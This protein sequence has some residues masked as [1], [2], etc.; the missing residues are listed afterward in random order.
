MPLAAAFVAMVAHRVQGGA[1][2]EHPGDTLTTPP[3][4]SRLCHVRHRAPR[5]RAGGAR[6]RRASGP[7][8][9]GTL[10]AR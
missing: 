8:P 2:G 3:A 10:G 6:G 7:R 9:P 5:S 1:A 4:R